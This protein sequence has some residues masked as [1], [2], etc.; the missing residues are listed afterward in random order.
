LKHTSIFA[1]IVA[2]LV[3]CIG[4]GAA[5]AAQF[6]YDIAYDDIL[7]GNYNL[8][9]GTRKCMLVTNAYTPNKA[10]H[11]K[12][13]DVTNE[14]TGT[15]YT[16]GGVT[17]TL[18]VTLDTTNHRSVITVSVP[19]WTTSTITAYA[20]VIYNSRGGASSADELFFYGDFG[21]NI[22][23]TASTFTVSFSAPIYITHGT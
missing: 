1:R 11:T 5:Q 21:G 3:L 7:K 14:V 13:S 20:L 12:R 17:C 10:T 4:F 8:S 19:A 23:S 9:S 15:G 22:S 16:A 6:T 2:A 18:A